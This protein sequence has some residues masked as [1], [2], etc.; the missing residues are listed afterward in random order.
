MLIKLPGTEC[1]SVPTPWTFGPAFS[2][3]QCLPGTCLKSQLQAS[4]WYCTQSLSRA[5]TEELQTHG[6]IS[7]PLGHDN[8]FTEGQHTQTWVSAQTDMRVSTQTQTRA[9]P[10]IP[11][12]CH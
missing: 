12:S 10:F 8:K 7:Y 5:N 1:L 3:P 4:L 9:E 11:Y 2:V 6:I